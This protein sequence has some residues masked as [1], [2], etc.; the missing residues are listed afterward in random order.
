L[1]P[2]AFHPEAD[3]EYAAAALYYAGIDP[4]L[5][6]RFY[7]DAEATISRLRQHPERF[8]GISPHLRRA[9]CRRFPYAII[10]AEEPDRVWILAVMHGRRRPGYW[11]ARLG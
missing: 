2:H 9:L 4:D 11:L 8:R 1:K 7:E 6:R 3:A 10:F 5:G